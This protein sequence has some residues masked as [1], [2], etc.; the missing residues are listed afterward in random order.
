[1]MNSATRRRDSS[2]FCLHERFRSDERPQSS[3]YGFGMFL[4]EFLPGCDA[5]DVA[6]EGIVVKDVI[7]LSP[8][9][10]WSVS[11]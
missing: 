10:F 1:M 8:N 6:V 5:R 7:P 4:Y 9:S 3:F 2:G 11:P